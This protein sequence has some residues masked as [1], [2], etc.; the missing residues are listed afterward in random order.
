MSE[1]EFQLFTV[2]MSMQVQLYEGLIVE[3][4]EYF[5]E[6]TSKNVLPQLGTRHGM[7]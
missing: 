4:Q 3:R 1:M 6:Q 2:H 7:A 5:T